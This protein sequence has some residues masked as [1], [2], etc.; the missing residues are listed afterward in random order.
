MPS[1]DLRRELVL[2]LD[3]QLSSLQKHVFGVL[4]EPELREYDARRDRIVELYNEI[5]EPPVAA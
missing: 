2:L 4:T 1:P 5:L 3:E